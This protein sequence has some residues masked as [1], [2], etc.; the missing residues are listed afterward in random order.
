VLEARCG[1]DGYHYTI[2]GDNF[3]P[4]DGVEQNGESAFFATSKFRSS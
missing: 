3:E 1:E 2:A 4:F